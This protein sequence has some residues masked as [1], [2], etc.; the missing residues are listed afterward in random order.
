MI[1]KDFISVIKDKKVD[2]DIIFAKGLSLENGA[3]T[4]TDF[5]ATQIIKALSYFGGSSE[6]TIWLVCGGGRKINI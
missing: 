4:L 6:G 2:F 5:T 3:S 1:E